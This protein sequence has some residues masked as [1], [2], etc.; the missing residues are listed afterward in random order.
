MITALSGLLFATTAACAQNRT[1]M[2]Q[3]TGAKTQAE[4]SQADGEQNGPVIVVDK[5]FNN[6]EIKVRKGG[7]FVVELEQLGSAGYEWVVSELDETSFEI[8]QVDTLEEPQP[9]DVTG[10]PVTRQWRIRAKKE[11]NPSIRF[12]HRR[13]WEGPEE[14]SDRF[15]LKVRI[16]P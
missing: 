14:A 10:A 8:V 5:Q 7:L 2:N 1:S 12:L 9:G 3:D 6:R 4:V 16:L 15:E 11:G 13:P